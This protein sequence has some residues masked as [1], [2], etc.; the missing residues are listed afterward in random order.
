M[1]RIYDLTIDVTDGDIDALGHVSNIAYVRWIQDAAVAHST[2]VGLDFDS[3]RRLGAVFVVRRHEIDYLRP[4]LRSD[5]VE[6]RTWIDT[7]MAAKCTRVTELRRA[8]DGGLAAKAL[9]TWGFIDA[10]TGR[11][12]RIP[13]ELMAPFGL[14]IERRTP[15]A[16]QAVTEGET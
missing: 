16:M 5:R 3:Y 7:A 11:P 14:V 9:T 13:S 4:V 1:T 2:A 15:R 6:A 8:S 12:T 10:V